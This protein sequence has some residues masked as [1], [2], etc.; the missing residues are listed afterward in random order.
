MRDSLLYILNEIPSELSLR[1]NLINL[2]RQ[3]RTHVFN[4]LERLDL[5]ILL[6]NIRDLLHQLYLRLLQRNPLDRE[7]YRLSLEREIRIRLNTS[8]N[9]CLRRMHCRNL[10][11]LHLE[12]NILLRPS[13]DALKNILHTDL[14]R[15]H[16]I[17][18]REYVAGML[19]QLVN[20][21]LHGKRFRDLNSFI[22]LVKFRDHL[23]RRLLKSINNLR[24]MRSLTKR[25]KRVLV[26]SSE[27]VVRVENLRTLRDLHSLLRHRQAKP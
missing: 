14:L 27:E 25:L 16:I 11:L 15:H 13:L 21:V 19:N 12:R 4:D 6:L 5:N 23:L 3:L 9:L 18:Q 26:E 2:R 17:I 1:K 10:F 8:T 24:K 20:T 22:D 7:I